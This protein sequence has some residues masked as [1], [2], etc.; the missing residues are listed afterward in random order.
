M[1]VFSGTCFKIIWTTLCTIATIATV[2]WQILNYAKD[3]D[4]TFVEFKRFHDNEM[5]IYPSITLC[6][7]NAFNEKELEKYGNNVNS[8]TYNLFLT[9]RIWNQ[10]MVQ[11]DY[12]KSH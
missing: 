12:N 5:D 3:D 9:G 10:G 8:I 2:A 6:F 7:T 1:F 11:I 4:V